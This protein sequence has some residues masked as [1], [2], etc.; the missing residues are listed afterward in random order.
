[1][2][3]PIAEAISQLK[4]HWYWGRERPILDFERFDSASR[5]PWGSLML[6]CSPRSWNLAALGAALTLAAIVLEPSLQQIPTYPLSRVL[7]PDKAY[8]SRAMHFDDVD[9]D[10]NGNTMVG[11][12][13]RG[14]VYAAMF[15]SVP[16]ATQS[17]SPSCS[18]GNCTWPSFK[19][20]GM[21]NTCRNVT[22]HI[23]KSIEY[24]GYPA[25][26]LPNRLGLTG[27]LS[28][29]N[30]AWML[31]GPYKSIVFNQSW[32]SQSVL[33]LSYIYLP[34]VTFDSNH[35]QA[36][37]YECVLYACVKTYEAYM[38]AGLYKETVTETWPEPNI[39]EPATADLGDM[40]AC[41]GKGSTVH[42]NADTRCNFP[43]TGNYTLSPP[44][45]SESFS[46]TVETYNF[47]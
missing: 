43:T 12:Q 8:T 4:W 28:N 47:L 20:L 35:T 15:D 5:G 34:P 29:G 6:L 36:N 26:D 10:G 19:S 46:F 40:F 23:S 24:N 42:Y 38:E 2:I 25:W 27:G 32:A 17:I 22:S 39:T 16:T 18:T 3:L 9:K 37:A 31:T 33:D 44:G 1:M 21:C 14:A 30:F 13:V 11:S 41:I 7:S 45:T